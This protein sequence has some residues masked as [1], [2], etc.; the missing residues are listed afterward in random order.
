MRQQHFEFV[1]TVPA[2]SKSADGLEQEQQ[3]IAGR[4]PVNCNEI[5]QII[6]TCILEVIRREAES[7]RRPSGDAVNLASAEPSASKGG[8]P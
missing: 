3:G 1:D 2:R 4:L 8:Q 7:D 6:A 5:R